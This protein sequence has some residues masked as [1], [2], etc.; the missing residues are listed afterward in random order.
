MSRFSSHWLSLREPIDHQSRNAGLQD[1]L[2]H[3]F[4]AQETLRWLI[5]ALAQDQ[6]Y[7][8]WRRIFPILKV[9]A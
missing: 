1:K 5:W 7:A 4:A 8:L 9:G 3:H 6:I 2:S